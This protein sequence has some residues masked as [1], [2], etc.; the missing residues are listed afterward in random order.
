MVTFGLHLR[1]NAKD[2]PGK[3]TGAAKLH[4]TV[5]RPQRGVEAACNQRDNRVEDS[6]EMAKTSQFENVRRLIWV[7]YGALWAE[8]YEDHRGHQMARLRIELG[9]GSAGY[10]SS[11]DTILIP[12]AEGNLDD[13]YSLDDIKNLSK[14]P[15][16]IIELVHE[17]LHEY[18][19][20]AVR[21]ASAEGRRLFASRKLPL[22]FSG[23]GHDEAFFTAIAEKA[24]SFSLMPA[25]LA[26]L[27]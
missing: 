10:I 6:P 15:V 9:D 7:T 24:A 19:H 27:L 8:W 26:A 3:A 21:V 16:W 1:A 4:L 25:E 11:Q 13:P 2:S 17:M 5:A 20:K 18:Q 23:E 22:T 14:C 12:L